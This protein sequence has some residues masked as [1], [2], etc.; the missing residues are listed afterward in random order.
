MS[1]LITK[2]MNPPTWGFVH[3]RKLDHAAGSERSAERVSA[4]SG[5]GESGERSDEPPSSSWRRSPFPHPAF[6][7]TNGGPMGLLPHRAR[8]RAV[9][10]SGAGRRSTGPGRVA[11]PSCP[12]RVAG[13]VLGSG[14]DVVAPSLG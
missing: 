10:R 9:V 6:P 1:G 3:P 2:V 12:T 5:D 8:H 14:A 4:F 13:P 11:S 7:R